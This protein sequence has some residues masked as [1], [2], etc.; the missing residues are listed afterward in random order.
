[1][2]G[3]FLALHVALGNWQLASSNAAG[4]LLIAKC[5]LPTALV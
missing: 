3:G 5:Q 1:M 4:H 2:V